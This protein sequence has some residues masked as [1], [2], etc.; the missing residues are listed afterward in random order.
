MS[1]T[2]ALSNAVSGLT[3]TARGTE[4]VAANL[5]NVM[6]PGYARREMNV[7]AQTLGGAGGGVRI[8]G[9][10]RAINA[11]LLAETRLADAA[12]AEAAT[13]LEFA[14]SMEDV[15]G[16]PGAPA[17]LGTALGAF[18]TALSEAA[19]RPDDETR[20]RG[21]LSTAQDLAQRLN[22]VS[23]TIQAKRG[24]ASD[25]ISHDVDVLNSSLDQV[26]YLNRRISI[27]AAQG[28][29]ASSLVDQRQTII[30]RINAI[31]PLQEVA[32]E[33][34][35]V[36]LF[37]VEGAVLLDGS[38]PSR[39]DV[40]AVPHLTPEM[41]V[42]TPPV[43]RLVMDGQEL[44]ASQMR[45]F[46]GGTLAANFSI[47]D[48]LAPQMQAEID[49]L[50]FELHERLSDP[51]VDLSLTSSDPALFTDAGSRADAT[52]L[53]GLAGRIAVSDVVNPAAGG[54]LWKLRDGLGAPAAGPVGDPALFLRL[55]D[56][57]DRVTSPPSA[58]VFE[59][60][61]SLTQRL[62]TLESRVSSQRVDFESISA[63]R[64][65]R[66]ETITTRFLDDGVDSDAEMQN[67]LRYEQ[68]YA[69][70]ARVI[71]AIDEMLNQVLRL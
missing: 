15:V 71:Q 2:K 16:L 58:S 11:G 26:A 67:L 52:G 31:V 3:A 59:G 33:A 47:R 68:A 50:A 12:S 18:R 45:L 30:D 9:V 41:T 23:D 43:G 69:A 62:A 46:A 8:D 36:A 13:R 37:T 10:T 25:A 38:K 54:D 21:V 56:A 65:S 5:A 66:S 64:N 51:A 53:V 60:N 24:Q 63:V 27:I 42:G 29:D 35:K 20:L 1:I 40:Q 32:R 4:T 34:G 49:S 14:Q 7:S 44:T 48:D 6:T 22:T 70:N 39:F 55:S 61:R 28:N 19:T 17:G 57:I